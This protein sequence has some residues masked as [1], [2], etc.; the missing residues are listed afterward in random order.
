MSKIT[1]GLFA[2][3][4]NAEECRKKIVATLLSAVCLQAA[5]R[6]GRDDAAVPEHAG[7]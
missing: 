6:F 5:F 1:R 2:R 3:L 7:G 4:A